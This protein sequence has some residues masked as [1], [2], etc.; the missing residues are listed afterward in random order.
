MTVTAHDEGDLDKEFRRG[1]DTFH[2]TLVMQMG[3][4]IDHD[5]THAPA[6]VKD[7]CNTTSDGTSFPSYFSST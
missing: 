4:F 6:P 3:Q 1:Q 5:I 7:C 2:T